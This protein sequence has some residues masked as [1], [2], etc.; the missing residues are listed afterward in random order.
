MN[1]TTWLV[2]TRNKRTLDW[3]YYSQLKIRCRTTN[4]SRPLC[5]GNAIKKHDKKDT[6]KARAI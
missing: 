1:D 2:K 4:K 5:A 6:A 3:L